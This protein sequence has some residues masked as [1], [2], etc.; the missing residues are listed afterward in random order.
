[1]IDF[2]NIN[3]HIQVMTDSYFDKCCR[4]HHIIVNQYDLI[5]ILRIIKNNPYSF[6]N[7]EYHPILLSKI[8]KETNI[9]TVNKIKPMIVEKYLSR[10]VK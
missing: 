3:H 1:M 9:D 4:N 8:E 7:E 5:I 2:Y 6:M 10:I